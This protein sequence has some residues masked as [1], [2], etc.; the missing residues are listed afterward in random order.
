MAAESWALARPLW[1]VVMEHPEVSESTLL[2]AERD[3]VQYVLAFTDDHKAQNA[4]D[5]LG[6]GACGRLVRVGPELHVELLTA[7]CQVGARGIMLDFEP[8]ACRYSW[9]SSL[10]GRS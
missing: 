4:L 2:S 5:W 6:A 10:I 7:M 9:L 8:D 3:S 1:L